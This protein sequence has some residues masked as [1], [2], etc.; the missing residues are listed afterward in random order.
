MPKGTVAITT[1]STE[2]CEDW[3]LTDLI[4]EFGNIFSWLWFPSFCKKKFVNHCTVI[5]QKEKHN[6]FA[7]YVMH[8]LFSLF[9]FLIRHVF[10]FFYC[11]YMIFGIVLVAFT[12]KKIMHSKD[13]C[14]FFDYSRS[15]CASEWCMTGTPCIRKA[16][17]LFSSL[18]SVQNY[19]PLVLQRVSVWKTVC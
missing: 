4:C 15:G 19:F 10:H 7:K 2:L 18:Y 16:Q 11:E 17:T 1:Q 12:V 14:N 9:S 5:L 13:L 8:Q 3:F 6:N